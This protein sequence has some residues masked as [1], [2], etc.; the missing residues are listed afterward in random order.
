MTANSGTPLKVYSIFKN[1]YDIVEKR[2][3]LDFGKIRPQFVYEKTP[4]ILK[5][6]CFKLYNEIE[7][8]YYD[9]YDLTLSIY[10]KYLNVNRVYSNSI[11]Y[12][13]IKE[14]RELYKKSELIKTKK[15][16]LNINSE[17]GFK[18][19]NEYF[20]PQEDGYALIYKLIKKRIISPVLFLRYFNFEAKNENIND[21]YNRFIY[22]MKKIKILLMQRQKNKKTKKH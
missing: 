1:C 14:V 20:K 18:N 7:N 21:E 15:I 11:D 2:R 9:Y 16:L 22:I 13:Y 8:G 17:V 4:N 6:N 19:V 5:H 3:D 12:K 10:N